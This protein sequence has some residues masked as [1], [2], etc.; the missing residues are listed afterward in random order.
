MTVELEVEE[1]VVPGV[2]LLPA[3]LHPIVAV[4][5]CTALRHVPQLL[6]NVGIRSMRLVCITQVR[7]P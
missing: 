5:A 1:R 7:L 6:T 2:E 4:S 3:L